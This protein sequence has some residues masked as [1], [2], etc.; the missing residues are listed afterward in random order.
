MEK[1]KRGQTESRRSHVACH[2]RQMHQNFTGKT[3]P[4][5]NT[6]I[7]RNG[8]TKVY[9]QLAIHL[10]D[11]PRSIANNIVFVCLLQDQAGQ[12]PPPT[13]F[14]SVPPTYS[15]S[16]WCLLDTEIY[17]LMSSLLKVPSNL[18]LLSHWPFSF[19]LSQSESTLVK[20]Y[21]HT[22]KQIKQV[23]IIRVATEQQS[24]VKRT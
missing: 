5:G 8:L 21:F 19:L 18:F 7:N 17:P 12:K 6:Q 16:A 11:W 9:S 15:T 23:R 4:H 2:Q 3:Q 20:I 24:T 1:I 14:L 13:L 22:Q 10:S